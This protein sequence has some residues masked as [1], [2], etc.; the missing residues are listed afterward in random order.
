MFKSIFY[1]KTFVLMINIF[2]LLVIFPSVQAETDYYSNSYVIIFGKC[3]KVTGPLVW[4]T[5][6]FIPMI[7]RNIRIFS[8][9]QPAES[10]SAVIFDGE[11][12]VYINMDDITFLVRNYLTIVFK[13]QY[14]I[15]RRKNRRIDMRV[16]DRLIHFFSFDYLR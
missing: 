5:P 13:I 12:G 1:R 16:S 9:G 8:Q 2:L 15:Y 3:T 7:K 11:K 4:I 14:Q 6:L 10:L